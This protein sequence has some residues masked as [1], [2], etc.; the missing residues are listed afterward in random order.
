MRDGDLTTERPGDKDAHVHVARRDGS[1]MPVKLRLLTYEGCE[2]ES[3]DRF[4]PA[5]RISIHIYRM[6][7]IRA[8]VTSCRK[9]VVQAEFIKDCPV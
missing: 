1:E 9:G 3:R 7:L 8:R 6:G 4:A 5:E 2:F